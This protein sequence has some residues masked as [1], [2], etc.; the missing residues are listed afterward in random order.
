MFAAIMIATMFGP[1]PSGSAPI[2]LEVKPGLQSLDTEFDP[3][4]VDIPEGYVAPDISWSAADPITLRFKTRTSLA[5]G[6]SSL[7]F[8]A[9]AGKTYVI[10]SDV[11]DWQNKRRTR[12]RWIIRV[13]GQPVPPKPTPPGPGPS[14]VR[15][16]GVAGLIFDQA[17]KVGRPEDA[18]R[19]AENYV[20]VSSMIAAGGIKTMEEAQKELFSAN[21]SLKLDPAH[22]TSFSE[23]LD[24]Y[25]SETAP[26]KSLVDMQRFMDEVAKGLEALTN[27]ETINGN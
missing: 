15:P 4:P 27:T 24:K 18:L 22:W 7:F 12:K 6:W 3:A 14:P 23:W 21:K 11:I 25:S 16:E 8:V 26:P 2:V 1:A 19:L 17:K 9:E 5:E 10:D 20:T 13:E